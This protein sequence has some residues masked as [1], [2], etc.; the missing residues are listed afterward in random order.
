[1]KQNRKNGGFLMTIVVIIVSLV[2]LKFVFN[3]DISDIFEYV[4]HVF[5]FIWEKITAIFN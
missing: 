4:K 2:I 3:K 5:V 1:M